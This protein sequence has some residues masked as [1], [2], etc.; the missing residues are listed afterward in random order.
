MP[1]RGK[2]SYRFRVIIDL[3][4]DIQDQR[5]QRHAYQHAIVGLAKDCQIRVLVKVIIQFL[6]L[7]TGI[8][9]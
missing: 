3:I 7:S 4:D 1:F 8:T 6:G 9:R 5:E 2:P